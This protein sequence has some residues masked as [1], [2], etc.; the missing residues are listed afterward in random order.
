MKNAF[1]NKILAIVGSVI[2]SFLLIIVGLLNFNLQDEKL[3]SYILESQ[4]LRDEKYRHNQWESEISK[5]IVSESTVKKDELKGNCLLDTM[6]Q[7]Y[8]SS[9]DMNVKEFCKR[10]ME[11][12]TDIHNKGD[13]L[14]ELSIIGKETALLRWMTE[15]TPAVEELL[16]ILEE[17]EDYTA[18]RIEKIQQK[19]LIFYLAMGITNG[20]TVFLVLWNIYKTYFYVNTEIVRPI[21]EIKE[22]TIRLAKGEL[23]LKFLVETENELSSL[24]EAL[25]LSID[26]LK[27]CIFAIEYVMKAFSDGDFTAFC[28]IEFKGDFKQIQTSIETFQETI[29]KAL[30]DIGQVSHQV[31]G[32]AG[33]IARAASALAQ[34]AENQSNSVSELSKITD[35]ITKQILSSAHYV[36]EVDSYGVKTGEIIETSRREMT[37]MVEAIGKIGDVST[38][39]S[40]IIQ[41]IDDISAQTNLLALNASIEAARAGEAGRGFA[42]VA[43]EISKLAKQSAEASHDIAELIQQSLSYIEDGQRYAKQMDHGFEV[44]AQSSHQV[45]EMIGKIADQAQRQA[46]AIQ[47]VLENIEV[48][49]DIVTSN[50]A[51]SEESFAA[52]EEL[53][54]QA[55]LLN[56]L[57]KRFQFKS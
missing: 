39:I 14:L 47:G 48:I 19:K 1:S 15:V 55:T 6:L 53:S 29:S 5:K 43:D 32:G 46:E 57:L 2:F 24:A 38:D 28:P 36:K 41:T 31:D 18:Q 56:E 45:I 8:A 52:S 9:K 30:V 25:Q 22:E 3:S 20:L 49:S 40:N 34:G 16:V 12:H 10:L 27:S 21:T 51:T 13:Q 7:E 35:D 26:H 33:E 11:I 37:Q 23:D 17:W 50:S 54:G 4:K 44:V 42:V